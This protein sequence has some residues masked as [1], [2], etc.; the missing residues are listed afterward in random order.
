[1]E[2]DINKLI[3][4][5]KKHGGS[6]LNKSN[7]EFDIEQANNQKNIFR[8]NAHLI[9]GIV[10]GHSFL[11]GCKSTALE[12]TIT[13]FEEHHMI[14]NEKQFAKGLVNIAK[15]K[16]DNI[17]KIEKMLRKWFKKI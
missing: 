15:N 12:I 1:M 4:I 5:N 3:E 14:C 8:S 6:L 11:D 10:C 17:N 2:I 13:R 16:I 9:R 7:L